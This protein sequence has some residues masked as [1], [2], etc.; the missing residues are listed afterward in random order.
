[1]RKLPV[2]VL[3]V[4]AASL[5]GSVS[6]PA[7]AERFESCTI[8]PFEWDI[9]GSHVTR[10]GT[11][12]RVDYVAIATVT[13]SG[14]TCPMDGESVVIRDRAFLL[15]EPVCGLDR[16]TPLHG[17]DPLN[18]GSGA[19]ME[20]RGPITGV[21]TCGEGGIRSLDM[22]LDA[23]TENGSRL[24]LHQTGEVD[25][26]AKMLTSLAVTGGELVLR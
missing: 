22:N 14:A 18:Y 11:L 8:A 10:E 24:V 25:L 6:A 4:A 17:T 23:K 12:V 19:R 15:F 5:T 7:A 13:H 26:T 9:V 3:A 20:F 1:M 16:T 2:W 21:V